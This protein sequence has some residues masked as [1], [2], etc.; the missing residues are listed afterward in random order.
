VVRMSRPDIGVVLRVE[1]LRVG[2]AT[3]P[4]APQGS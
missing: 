4:R 1:D 3:Y 2:I